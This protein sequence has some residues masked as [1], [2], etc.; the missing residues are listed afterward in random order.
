MTLDDSAQLALNELPDKGT[1]A[2]SNNKGFLDN[3]NRDISM[4]WVSN[5]TKVRLFRIG[6]TLKVD[7]KEAGGNGYESWGREFKMSDFSASPVIKV[8]ARFEGKTSPVL[9]LSLKDINSYDANFDAPTIKLKEG[10]Y[11]DYYFNFKDR[12]KQSWPDEKIVDVAAIREIT[13]FINPGAENWTGT[14]Y[15]DEIK[16][17]KAEDI[18]D[19]NGENTNSTQVNSSNVKDTVSGTV[20]A[21]ENDLPQL[22]DDFKNEIYNWWAGSDKI[23]L[24]KEGETLKVELKDVGPGF[25]NWGRDFKAINFRKIPIVKIRMKASG[26]KPALLRIDLKD[27]DGS[28]TNAKPSIVKFETGTDFVD[29]YFD[30]TGKF[31]QSYP[32]VKTVNPSEITELV[33]FV[34]PGGELYTGTIFI[35]EILAI[36]MDD[37]K[38]KK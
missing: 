20:K 19:K 21:Q 27:A 23:K 7:L 18:P 10:G 38:N 6:D 34:N 5:N 36:S 9:R 12:W 32:N 33:F 37:Y 30:F 31:E 29:Y 26:E 14:I 11:Q 28:V 22:I 13:F 16:P 35:D 25:E 4:W 2:L 24:M 15:I 3:F 17:V 1:P 8:R